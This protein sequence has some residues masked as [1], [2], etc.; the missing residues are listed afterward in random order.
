MSPPSKLVRD[1]KSVVPLS[2]PWVGFGMRLGWDEVSRLK[3]WPVLDMVVQFVIL[4]LGRL[5]QEVEEFKAWGWG[6]CLAA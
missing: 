1:G 3:A 4:A 5:R 2:S 6:F